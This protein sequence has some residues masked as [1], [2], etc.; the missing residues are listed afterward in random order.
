MT[1][2]T[3]AM[4]IS[5]PV[6]AYL[7]G[8]IPWGIVIAPF[9]TP[10]DIRQQG[11]GNIGATNVLRIAGF[12]A[13]ALVLTADVLKGTL[14]LLLAVKMV[15]ISTM[16]GQAYLSFVALAA[17]GGHLYPLYLGLKDGGKGVATA[18]GCL[19]VLSPVTS[20]ILILIFVLMVCMT[21]RVSVGSLSGAAALPFILWK[22]TGS[23]ALT[24][25]AVV[26]SVFIFVRHKENIL[27]LINGTESKI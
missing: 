14:P 25:C 2:S 8:S 10:K 23:W 12:K 15:N 18:L 3:I 9:F 6:L 1:L 4:L 17:F 22:S 13:G 26:I 24:L 27:R 19:L 21:G 5:L 11:S 16:S 20:L 7:F